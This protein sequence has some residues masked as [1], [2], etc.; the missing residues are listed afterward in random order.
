MKASSIGKPSVFS[1]LIAESPEGG[2]PGEYPIA[3]GPLLPSSVPPTDHKS[4]PTERA[5]DFLVNTWGADTIRTR[6]LQRHGPHSL[7]RTRDEAVRCAALLTAAGWLEEIPSRRRDQ[8][9]WRIA[10]KADEPQPST[11]TTVTG[12]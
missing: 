7:R 6:D 5:L 12:R 8:K 2:Q 4:S 1:K 9:T 10:R 3:R 11:V